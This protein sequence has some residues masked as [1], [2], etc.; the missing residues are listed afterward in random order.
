MKKQKTDTK[1]K[2]KGIHKMCRK[3]SCTNYVYYRPF[4]IARGLQKFCSNSCKASTI[5]NK[6][7]TGKTLICP[8]CATSFY[9]QLNE[10][11]LGRLCCSPNCANTHKVGKPLLKKRTGSHRN[12]L[13]CKKDFYAAFWD[14]RKYCSIDCYSETGAL[15]YRTNYNPQ[16]IEVIEAFGKQKGY[17]FLHAENGGEYR[18]PGTTY[19]VDAYDPVKNVV[20]EIDEHHHYL[21]DGSLRLKDVERQKA[22]ENLLK[23][24]FLRIRI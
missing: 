2:T 16:S 13:V 6:T 15:R 17:S 20:L 23:C 4:E 14:K 19:F 8:N 11:R 18:V 1:A 10:I 7:K 5:A 9:A 22:I 21:S 24:K 12:C 3:V